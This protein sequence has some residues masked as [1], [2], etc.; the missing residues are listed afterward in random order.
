MPDVISVAWMRF[1]S[2]VR[3]R[4]RCRRKRASS[5]SRRIVGSGSQIA[6]TK[7]DRGDLAHAHPQ[8]ALRSGRRRFSSSSR[9]TA[10]FGIAPPE[11]AS[12]S[13][14]SPQRQRGDRDTSAARH[15]HTARGPNRATQHGLDHQPTFIETKGTPRG[16]LMAKFP[17]GVHKRLSPS[18]SSLAIASCWDGWATTTGRRAGG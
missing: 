12:H 2:V 15:P 1:F 17:L 6:G 16:R 18:C 13:A 8:S 11:R 10:H 7:A 9:L 3:C 14:T 5:R 4:T